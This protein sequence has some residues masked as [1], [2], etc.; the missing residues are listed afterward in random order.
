MQDYVLSDVVNEG[1]IFFCSGYGFCIC[2]NSFDD[3]HPLIKPHR[4]TLH[5]SDPS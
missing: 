2:C 4:R 3:R 1:R 5:A